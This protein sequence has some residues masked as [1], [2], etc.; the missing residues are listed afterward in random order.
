MTALHDRIRGGALCEMGDLADEVQTL[1]H[2]L[3]AAH[4]RIAD[5]KEKVDR[6]T[7]MLVR[8]SDSTVNAMLAESRRQGQREVLHVVAKHTDITDE[9]YLDIRDGIMTS[10]SDKI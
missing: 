7:R 6:C 4:G 1:Q 2:E 9:I 10:D 8:T 5:L 3:L